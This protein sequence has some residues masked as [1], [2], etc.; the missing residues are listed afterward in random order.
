MEG[1]DDELALYDD[2]EFYRWL[3][4]CEAGMFPLISAG[5]AVEGQSHHSYDRLWPL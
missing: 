1:R 4:D 5:D 3:T 2:G